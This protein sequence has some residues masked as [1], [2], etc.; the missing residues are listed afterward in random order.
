M[1][2]YAPLYDNNNQII[3][4]YFVGVPIESVNSILDEGVALTI[5]SVVVFS[6]VL[7]SLAFVITLFLSNGITKPIQRITKAAQQIADGNFDVELSV[8]SK[9][10]WGVL[11]KPLT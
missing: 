4:I 11:P 1:T 5:K 9:M 8:R 3:G 10:R 2:G 6:I 7:L